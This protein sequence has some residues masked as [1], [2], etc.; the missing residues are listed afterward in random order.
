MLKKRLL[1]AT[2][3]ASL[4]AHPPAY[5]APVAGMV[6]IENDIK[7][8]VLDW[9][10][11]G[12]PL[13]FLAG[14]G[15][16]AHT[17]EGLAERFTASHHV[18]AITRRGFG[19]SSHPAPTASAYSVE[20][21][22]ADVMT[23]VAK[24]RIDRPFI[25][26]HSVAGEE[27]SE[28]GVHY[29]GKIRGLI[30]LDAAD[31]EAFYGPS[32]DVLYPIAGE[33]KRDLDRLISAQPSEAPSI[34]AKIKV[35]LPRLERGLDWYGKAVKGVPDF[36]E[37][38]VH[39]QERGLQ[40]AIVEGGHAYGAINASILAIV[41]L[42]NQCVPDCNSA[43]SMRRAKSDEMQIE[44]FSKANPSATIVKL[45]YADHFVWKSNEQAVISA[46]NAFM[47]KTSP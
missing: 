25:A 32:S 41:A 2:C 19:A 37:T 47:E 15:G 13:V 10:G 34:I 1:I 46:M 16:T 33:V 42:P 31:A 30:Y 40:D 20:R 36:P 6:P 12:P 28:I 4:A 38:V 24:L 23:V 22:A 7:V 11:S 9:G 39:S 5:A 18:Y 43:A 8:E 17:F 35:E 21:L 29:P 26:G 44:E 14:F 45:P 3:L 27:L